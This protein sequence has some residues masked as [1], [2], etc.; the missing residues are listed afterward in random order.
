MTPLRVVV[1]GGSGFVGRTLCARLAA[2]PRIGSVVVPTRRRDHAR[3]LSVLP[4]VRCVESDV[5]D[6]RAARPR[7]PAEGGS[8]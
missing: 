4:A 1:T 7:T 2:D 3:A 6:P 5:H 8:L